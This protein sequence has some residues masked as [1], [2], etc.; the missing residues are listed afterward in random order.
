M[1]FEN[2]KWRENGGE[3]MKT[4]LTVKGMHCQSCKVLIEDVCAE[5][6]GVKSCTLDFKSGKLVVEH[7]PGFDMKKVKK[8]I[9]AAGEYKVIV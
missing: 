9:E 5:I 6:A 4:T 7:E 8:E 1:K 3:I 2:K